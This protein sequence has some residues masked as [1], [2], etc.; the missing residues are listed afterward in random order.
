[1]NFSKKIEM[2][3]TESMHL[4]KQIHQLAKELKITAEDEMMQNICEN[5]TCWNSECADTLMGKEVKICVQLSAE[6]DK[7]NAIAEEMENQIRRMYQSEL[8]NNQL[9]VTRIY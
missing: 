9:A 2:N 5:K 4:T 3:F 7:L 6:A 8:F 1:M